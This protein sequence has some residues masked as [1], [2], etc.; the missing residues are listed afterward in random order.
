MS[1]M[2]ILENIRKNCWLHGDNKKRFRTMKNDQYLRNDSEFRDAVFQ[3]YNDNIALITISIGDI[4]T[5]M[6]GLC[7]MLRSSVQG[8]GWK[9]SA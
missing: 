1:D 2:F 8:S 6:D 7:L 5:P 9:A 4:Y 3:S